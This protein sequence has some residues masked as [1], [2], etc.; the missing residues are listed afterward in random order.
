MPSN[1]W[2]KGNL[3]NLT[4]Q[5]FISEL[6]KL[7]IRV[8]ANI[9]KVEMKKLYMENRTSPSTNADIQINNNVLDD[10]ATTADT[11]PPNLDSIIEDNNTPL[12][13]KSKDKL[14]KFHQDRDL[15]RHQSWLPQTTT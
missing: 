2:N 7:G 12:N 11:I 6:S 3:N 13:A 15:A 1:R 9:R 4:M 5:R 10:K 8:P 14:V